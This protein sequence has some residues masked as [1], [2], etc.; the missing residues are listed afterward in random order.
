MGS[1]TELCLH[2]VPGHLTSARLMAVLLG[3]GQGLKQ[4]VPQWQQHGLVEKQE[5]L[6]H[7]IEQLVQG[8]RELLGEAGETVTKTRKVGGTVVRNEADCG[9]DM[10]PGQLQAGPHHGQQLGAPGW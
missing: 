5:Q 1:L 3:P 9:I 4:H 8:I 7:R 10:G 6:P 2:A